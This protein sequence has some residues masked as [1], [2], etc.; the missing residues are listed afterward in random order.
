MGDKLSIYDLL[1]TLVPGTLV[2]GLLAIAMPCLAAHFKS[3][4]L[5]DVFAGV[6]L[7]AVAI[8]AGNVIQ[9]VGSLID[10]LLNWTWIGT[11]RRFP[12][13]LALENGLGDRYLPKEAADRIREK[14]TATV[15]EG[16]GNR[17][18]F[19]YAMQQAEGASSQ[20]VST[21][22][23]LVAYHRALLIATFAGVV[24]VV[25]GMCGWIT[26]PWSRAVSWVLL[27]ITVVLLLLFWYRTKQRS[28][29]YVREVLLTA[30]RVIDAR[31][32]AAGQQAPHQPAGVELPLGS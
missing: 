14:L 29:Y 21:F 4:S 12:S 18:L 31:P 13:E 27:V 16:T 2:V 1:A 15:K 3:L 11:W 6:V 19:L 20:R 25:V 7:T 30:E 22:N 28:F 10:P 23:G 8:F 5:P 32:A 9:A 24:V 26:V 17:S